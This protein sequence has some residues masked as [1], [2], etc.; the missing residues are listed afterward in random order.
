MRTQR[1]P[2]LLSCTCRLALR[3]LHYRPAGIRWGRARA[4]AP[5]LTRV[6]KTRHLLENGHTLPL[7]GHCR[8]NAASYP[9][10][11]CCQARFPLRPPVVMVP[12]TGAPRGKSRA[13][14]A[15]TSGRNR[16]AAGAPGARANHVR[17]AYD[18][19]KFPS[20]SVDG[21]R[22]NPEK[23]YGLAIASPFD[24]SPGTTRALE[25]VRRVGVAT[26]PSP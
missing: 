26:A 8:T 11:N 12:Q 3:A 20:R 1:G 2:T 22:G 19:A 6:S 23:R 10:S 24:V 16:L 18:S 15:T 21:R 25:P 14:T 5:A 13:M 4:R 7:R 17:A 9:A